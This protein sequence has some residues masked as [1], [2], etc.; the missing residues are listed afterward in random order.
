MRSGGSLRRLEGRTERPYKVPFYVRMDERD[1][2]RSALRSKGEQ[3]EMAQDIREA[4]GYRP[5]PA[6][7]LDSRASNAGDDLN[8]A[9]RLRGVLQAVKDDPM[10]C[11]SIGVWEMVNG[12]LLRPNVEA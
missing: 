3:R 12:A 1:V 9:A 11:H 10:G 4:T 8:E 5:E 7:R 6:E 2:D